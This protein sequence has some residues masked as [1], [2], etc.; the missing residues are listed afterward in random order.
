M[1]IVLLRPSLAV[2]VALIVGLVFTVM[3]HEA[4]HMIVAK[5]SGMKVTEFFLGFGPRIWSFRRGETEYG[6]KAIPA[7]GYVRIIGM[8]SIEEVDPEDEARTY[9]A[10]SFPK[11][12]ATILAGIGV[13]LLIAFVL[14]FVVLL[15]VGETKL[16]STVSDVSKGYPAAEAGIRPGD[17]LVT[18]GGVAVDSFADL[19]DQVSSRAGE[20]TTIVV[21]RD[22]TERTFEVTPKARSKTDPSGLIGVDR[23]RGAPAARAL[24]VRARVVRHDVRRHASR[25]ARGSRGSSRRRA[26]SARSPT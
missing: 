9:R 19:K 24:R 2:T 20:R 8:N 14:I 17:R 5:R 10:A 11:R 21:E 1:L 25:P 15:R 4:G 6:I 12:L 22:G 18:I 26:S 3:L 16:T 23:I 13:N 7:G